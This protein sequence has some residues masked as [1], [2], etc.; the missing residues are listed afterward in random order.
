MPVMTLSPSPTD[1]RVGAA[2][3]LAI[4]SAVARFGILSS[5]QI[6]QLD[7]GS[8]QK[9]TRILQRLVELKLLRVVD[10]APEAF[11]S[12]FFDARPR[13]F[14]VTSAGLRALADAGMSINVSPK[15]TN[16]LLA[17]EIECAAAMFLIGKGVARHS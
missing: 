1:R 9:C 13:A 15:R 8:R 10:R 5:Q 3:A 6:A 12:S 2:R 7:G 17:H 14:A 4:V 16:V 11:L